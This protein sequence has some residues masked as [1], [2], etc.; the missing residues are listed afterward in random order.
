METDED[1]NNPNN[2]ILL[3]SGISRSKAQH[4][5]NVGDWNRE[6][7][8]AKSHGDFGTTMGAGTDLHHLR[9]ADLTVNSTRNNLD[10]D[11][12]A[13]TPDT[14]VKNAP[15]N[16]Y[17]SSTLEPRD[18]VKGDVA[19][20]IMYIPVRYSGDK[21]DEPKLIINEKLNNGTSSPIGYMGKLSTLLKW[22]LQDLPDE[23]EINRNNVIEEWQGNRN[24]FIDYPEFATMIWGS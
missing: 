7:V 9:P 19:R 8:W 15:G 22:N 1:P 11:E 23:F 24:P 21:T 10:F 16:Y 14:A 20:M 12:V 6:H 3:Y 5:G 18:E 2:V 13:H 4:G 17:T